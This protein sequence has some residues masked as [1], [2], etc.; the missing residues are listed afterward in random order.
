MKC[1]TLRWAA[2]IALLLALAIPGCGRHENPIGAAQLALRNR[3]YA[4]AIEHI[5]RAPEELRNTYEAQALLGQAHFL[6]EQYEECLQAYERAAKLDPTRAD[7]L[8]RMAEVKRDRAGKA[9]LE[10]DRAPLR[11]SGLQYCRRA[12]E[13]DAENPEVFH[14]MAQL[15]RAG[16]DLQLAIEAQTKSVTYAPDNAG[17]KLV[18][19]RM[20]LEAEEREKAGRLLDEALAQ[21]DNLA[22]ARVLRGNLLLARGLH[23]Q[24]RQE[25]TRV[26]DQK[27]VSP[28][29]RGDALW[30]L[31]RS[32]LA[33][34][35]ID[36]AARYAAL[37]EKHDKYRHIARSMAG[38]VH[39][40]KEEWQKA[41]DKLKPLENAEN[42]QVVFRLATAEE[43]LGLKNQAI[44]HYQR[45]IE[46][47]DPKHV[48]ARM[49]LTRLM[50]VGGNF[51]E[52]M[53]HCRA[54]LGEQPNNA[55]ALRLKARIHRT[56]EGPLRNFEQAR[57]IYLRL[58]SQ[59]RESPELHILLSELHLDWDRLD[60]ALAYALE[61]GRRRDDALYREILGRVYLAMHLAGRT[62]PEGGPEYLPAATENLEKAHGLDPEKASGARWLARAYLA[63]RTPRKAVAIL[64][65]FVA[66]H[67][68]EGQAHQ[69]LA[70]VYEAMAQPAKAVEVLENASRVHGV[71]NLDPGML[72]R[73]HFLNGDR[74]R[75]IDTWQQLLTE[76]G[77]GK[78]RTTVHV[79]LAVTLA[80]EGRY[81][82][83]LKEADQ[84]VRERE[85]GLPALFLAACVAV[86]G[87]QFDRAA[88]YLRRGTY[89]S[90]KERE[91]HLAFAG[92]CRKAGPPGRKAAALMCEA[93]L[94]L[95][96]VNPQA[97]LSRLQEAAQV[98]PRSIV[99]RYV[100]AE[101][102]ARTRRLS[103]LKGVYAAIFEDFPS[104]GYPHYRL[105][106]L[107]RILPGAADYRQQ[108]DLALDLDPGLAVAH[109]DLANLLLREAM[110]QPSVARLE[111]AVAH[112]DRGMELDEGRSMFPL[113]IAASAHTSTARYLRRQSLDD[114]DP[115]E[116]E[117]KR[118][119]ADE[120]VEK[121]RTILLA[122]QKKFPNSIEAARTRLRFELSEEDYAKVSGLALRYLQQ[123]PGDPELRLIAAHAFT[124]LGKLAE[125]EQQLRQLIRLHPEHTTAYRDLA[126]VYDRQGRPAN[127]LN[128]LRA[129][130]RIEPTDL[131]TRF[132]LAGLNLRYG[133]PDRSERIYQNLLDRIP[134]DAT[135]PGALQ[136]RREAALGL[137]RVLIA[138]PATDKEQRAANLDR[139][140]DR[141]KPLTDPLPGQLPDPRGLLALGNIRELQERH[142][143]A[144][145]AYLRC[146][147]LSPKFAPA[148][149]AV[150]VLYYR[151]G[152]YDEAIRVC[153]EP[154]I[155]GWPSNP[156]TYARTA[157][158]HV[159]RGDRDDLEQAKGLLEKVGSYLRRRVQPHAALPIEK[160]EV[161][162]TLAVLIR[163]AGR[164]P[165]EARSE[166]RTIE[167][168][169]A[170]SKD[171]FGEL[172][173]RS[174]RNAAER[175]ALVS[176]LAAALFY[177]S[178]GRPSL[179]ADSLREALELAP[180]NLYLLGALAEN[181]RRDNDLE[182][183]AET[184]DKR[185]GLLER[186]AALLSHDEH[187]KLYWGLLAAYDRLSGT[188]PSALGKAVALCERA[189][190]RWPQSFDFLGRL[191]ALHAAQ[192]D[193]SDAIKG[194]EQIAAS[195][196]EGSAPWLRAKQKLALLLLDAGQKRRAAAVALEIESH[197]QSSPL[198]LN[199]VAW[200]LAVAPEPDLKKAIRLAERAK[201]LNPQSPQFRD[202]LGWIYCL[203][204][205][206]RKAVAELR[207]AAKVLTGNATVAYHYGAALLRGGSPEGARHHLRR[208]V[209]LH[210]NGAALPEVEDCKKLLEEAEQRLGPAEEEGEPPDEAGSPEH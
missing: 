113:E 135:A 139:A 173:D 94:H 190:T 154:L 51:E 131:T 39:L 47:L 37:L 20:Y 50:I 16:G 71:E 204:G 201:E 162:R 17:A 86:Q 88:E 169:D 145:A 93:A 87:G 72:A 166:I 53:Q 125:A 130:L 174:A 41:Y 95:E 116:I 42:A 33:T 49:A 34:G 83:A 158:L 210:R 84:V 45:I 170:A 198:W 40:A 120:H 142:D 203:A 30:G 29:L 82:K 80:L 127:A 134:Q 110:T 126:A 26:V 76:Y 182:A 171:A 18:L 69:V 60:Q 177:T 106:K 101:A 7:P 48:Q 128:A 73:A 63:N 107:A 66:R 108:I 12:L 183:Y 109:V 121:A 3:K 176:S 54:V 56:A 208:A 32:S 85:E 13:V 91:T 163:I 59:D 105:A 209:E 150:L 148:H 206:H 103:D 77:E 117:A 25:Y 205:Q 138:T 27:G 14:V 146:A 74:A 123:W 140:I 141:L 44:T 196:A 133:R 168:L 19:A 153:T 160:L 97:A 132:E 151:Q 8:I 129:A 149:T 23:P 152:R 57:L 79:G 62:A 15:H 200:M 112:A 6:A 67:P 114:T 35:E 31:A 11:Q 194:F 122:L 90:A 179:A 186:S 157:L 9:T 46:K 98:L 197:V 52:A 161:Y 70:I 147:E 96:F 187:Q 78:G 55:T 81:D 100:L 65:P 156:H 136:V 143:D 64:Q 68:Q 188:D 164:R 21:D 180:D 193:K 115:Q 159:A 102:M 2:P 58:L 185:L 1:E 10:A 38:A 89:A 111:K 175:K 195:S 104:H 24:A 61:A 155:P 124:R 118:A 22:P 119:L 165:A 4:E 189:T 5:T 184:A 92:E 207:Q 43:K 172:V 75:A 144:L 28:G 178:G 137:A 191:A 181:R 192:G 199:N 36:Q 202:T 167:G 99:V